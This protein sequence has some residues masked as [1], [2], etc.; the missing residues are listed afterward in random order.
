MREHDGVRAGDHRAPSA[1]ENDTSCDGDRV[2]HA[3]APFMTALRSAIAVLKYAG[4]PA[5]STA[6]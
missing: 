2:L 6:R 5:P 4:T 1:V 3:T